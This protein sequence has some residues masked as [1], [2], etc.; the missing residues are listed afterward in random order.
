MITIK[1]AVRVVVVG[2]VGCALGTL[3]AEVEYGL[4]YSKP[5]ANSH[6]SLEDA[7][8]T[9]HAELHRSFG[10]L[11]KERLEVVE[12]ML[13]KVTLTARVDEARYLLHAINECVVTLR[14]MVACVQDGSTDSSEC[15]SLLLRNIPH[16]ELLVERLFVAQC[17]AYQSKNHGD[18]TIRLAPREER[19]YTQCADLLEYVR[20][21]Y[22][23]LQSALYEVN[24]VV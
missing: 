21:A 22:T 4:W 15:R 12:R 9:E 18:D 19:I 8:R 7:R 16:I 2:A 1:K 24:D 20:R 11:M 14:R 13:A 17:R 5:Q 23:L 6:E 10:I 3:Q